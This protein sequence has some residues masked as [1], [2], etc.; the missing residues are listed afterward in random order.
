L[1]IGDWRSS[2]VHRRL[3]KGEGRRAKDKGKGKGEG[4]GRLILSTIDV[5]RLSTTP[6]NGIDNRERLTPA[7]VRK[8]FLTAFSRCS[9]FFS[10]RSP[11]HGLYGSQKVLDERRSCNPDRKA[12]V[13][14]IVRHEVSLTSENDDGIEGT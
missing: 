11:T 4:L 5:R 1:A 14:S 6:S 12:I 9:A 7:E 3:A 8:N 10:L 13:A 2:I